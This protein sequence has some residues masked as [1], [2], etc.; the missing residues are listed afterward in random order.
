MTQGIKKKQKVHGLYVEVPLRDYHLAFI[1]SGL[2]LLREKHVKNGNN[3]T[4]KFIDGLREYIRR[5]FSE[6]IKQTRTYRMFLD[7]TPLGDSPIKE[8]K[9]QLPIV[10]KDPDYGD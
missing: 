9:P 7:H 8:K 6:L 3:G 2:K 4:V 1:L 5:Y 10:Y